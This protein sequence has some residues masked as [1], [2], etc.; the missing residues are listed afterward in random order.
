MRVR[1]LSAHLRKTAVRAN[2]S[3]HSIFVSSSLLQQNRSECG[4]CARTVAVDEDGEIAHFVANR[5]KIV[6]FAC[7]KV[8]AVTGAE[9]KFAF[10]DPVA[11]RATQHVYELFAGMMQLAGFYFALAGNEQIHLHAATARRTRQSLKLIAFV[12]DGEAAV[13]SRWGVGHR[14]AVRIAQ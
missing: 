12:S 4:L 9:M 8:Q 2:I 10:T 1:D 6:V 3:T 11:H 7:I 14:I 5:F 13:V